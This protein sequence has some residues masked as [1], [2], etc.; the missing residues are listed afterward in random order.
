MTLVPL[1]TTVPWA[2]VPTAEIESV[3]P[4]LSVALARGSK[5]SAAPAVAV[6]VVLVAVGAL[7]APVTVALTVAVAA[8]PCPSETV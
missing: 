2:A 8:P 6:R 1:L 3:S 4:L 5:V 7:L